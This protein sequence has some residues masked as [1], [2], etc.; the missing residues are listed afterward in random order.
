MLGF[1]RV[2]TANLGCLFGM[3]LSAVA[4][5]QA[6]PSKP[7]RWLVP[8]PP[9]GGADIV[10]RLAANKMSESMGQPVIVE[11]RP[12]A[13]GLV[14]VEVLTKSPPDG[15]T[16]LL[17]DLATLS[18][19]SVLYAKL[20][21]DAFRDFEPVTRLVRAAPGKLNYGIPGVGAPHHLAMELFLMHSGVRIT[22]V[23]Y[24]GAAPAV[25]ELLANRLD[26]MFLDLG[27][28]GASAK[29]GKLKALAVGDRTRL[30]Q[31]PGVPTV[32][33]LGYPEFEAFAWSGLVAPAK[34]PR[35]IVNRLNAEVAKALADPSSRQR[36]SE[37]GFEGIAGTPEE[38][39]KFMRDE[40]T[41]WTRVIRAADI[42]VE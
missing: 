2:V 40:Q 33:E 6:Y 35:E 38:L 41:K 4:L 23:A 28:G 26:T 13:S 22:N 11:N 1:Q 24:K 36:M 5:A 20:P 15:Y 27:S 3:A 14:A 17:G 25:Q 9:G 10:A 7:L 19:N 37:I 29:A 21:Y 16:L 32:A 34:T 39:T 31:F 12:G 8:Y 30:A 42:K 18:L